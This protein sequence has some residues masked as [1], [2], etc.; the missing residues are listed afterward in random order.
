MDRCR[1][2]VSSHEYPC[3]FKRRR[4]ACCELM[5]GALGDRSER[6]SVFLDK[7]REP[8]QLSGRTLELPVRNHD[9]GYVDAARL[10]YVVDRFRNRCPGVLGNRFSQD[11]DSVDV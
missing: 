6:H 8:A 2:V 1:R 3:L 10:Q 4:V 9:R 7:R 11:N 5:C